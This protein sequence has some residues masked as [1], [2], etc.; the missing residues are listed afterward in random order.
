[1]TSRNTSAI[2]RNEI[3]GS[4]IEFEAVC[5]GDS[6]EELARNETRL[7]ELLETFGVD[8]ADLVEG[9]YHEL[10]AQ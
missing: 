1:M 10:A 7:R 5:A 9:S 2:A 6:D 8:A 3:L 4:F